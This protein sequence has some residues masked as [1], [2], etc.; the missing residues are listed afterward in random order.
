MDFLVQAFIPY[1]LLYKYWALFVITFLAASSL[2]IPAG[3]LLVASSAFAS[4]GYFN[5]ATL[6]FVVVVANL[7]GDNLLYW[8]SRLYGKKFLA[9]FS[10][11]NK[12]LKSSNYNLIE[13]NIAKRPG[14]VILLSRF[15]VI[16]TLT[17]NIICGLSKVSYRKFLIFEIIGTFANVIFYTIIGYSFGSSWQAVNKLIG[18]FTIVFF[19]L[20]ALVI[21]LFWKNV[22]KKLNEN[23]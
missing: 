11:T 6:L 10:L 19:L 22:I 2:P 21:S 1:I 16:S 17:I 9:K 13:K 4:Q 23:I 14:L 12:I 8:L 3:T 20:I 5:I 18:D 7:L 15:E